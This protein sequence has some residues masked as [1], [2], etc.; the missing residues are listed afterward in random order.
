MKYIF[1]VLLA[2]SCKV[3][4]AQLDKT[5]LDAF[6]HRIVKDK[7]AQFEIEY[8]A[9]E[10][11]KDVFELDRHGAKIVLRGSNGLSVASALNYYLKNYCHHLITWNG[12]PTPLPGVLPMVRKKV[13]RNTP[14]QYRY[15]INY[16][17]FQYSMAW[18]DWD[19][20][21]RDQ[22]ARHRPQGADD[23]ERSADDRRPCDRRQVPD[24]RPRCGRRH[25][26]R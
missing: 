12:A 26:L 14:Y 2:L 22:R 19:R 3:V 24:I 8:L 17:T 10:G 5:S 4:C 21:Q 9:Q 18:W 23:D 20:W 25:R 16:C 15:Y 7:A 11:G 6:L 1:C 13:H